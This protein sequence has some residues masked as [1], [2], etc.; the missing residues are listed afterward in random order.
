MYYHFKVFCCTRNLVKCRGIIFNTKNFWLS[1]NLATFWCK[2]TVLSIQTTEKVLH[3]TI[4][5]SSE[6]Y[7]FAHTV[8]CHQANWNAKCPR[9]CLRDERNI[10]CLVS[11]HDVYGTFHGQKTNDLTN[12]EDTTLHQ[13]L[14]CGFLR[15]GS[16]PSLFLHGDTSFFSLLF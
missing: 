15:L 1:N 9:W 12:Y 2:M 5:C 13:R 8:I 4:Y 3:W 7:S 16:E 10:R 6:L 11:I 14:F